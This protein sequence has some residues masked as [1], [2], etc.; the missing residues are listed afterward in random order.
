MLMLFMRLRRKILKVWS[1]LFS[2]EFNWSL[3][4]K[5][6]ALRTSRRKKKR[7]LRRR[8][9]DRSPTRKTRRSERWT[10]AVTARTMRV[11]AR[12]MVSPRSWTLARAAVIL[13]KIRIP[14]LR[15]LRWAHLAV[16]SPCS[17]ISSIHRLVKQIAIPIGILRMSVNWWP[18]SS[19]GRLVSYQ[20]PFRIYS[21]KRSPGFFWKYNNS[22]AQTQDS[23]AAEK[24]NTDSFGSERKLKKAGYNAQALSNVEI[25]WNGKYLLYQTAGMTVTL[26]SDVV[27]LVILSNKF[28]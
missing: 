27:A 3:L 14:P 11:L 2:T 24:E 15:L 12:K 9:K 17:P 22:P 1:S 23:S 20:N 10:T 5:L 6:W 28:S 8:R 26:F 25:E 18:Y 7:S 21:E 19:S 4:G 13:A 16:F